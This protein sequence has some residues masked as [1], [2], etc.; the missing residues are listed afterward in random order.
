MNRNWPADWQ[1]DHIQGGAG[2]FPLSWP[3]TNC[4]AL[5]ILDHT[6]IAG[7]QSFHNNGGMILRGP[8]AVTRQD[9]T[10]AADDRIA[11][12][13]G[14]VGARMIPFYR[15]MVIYRDLYTVHGGFVNW[16]YEHLGIFSFTNELWNTDQMLGTPA[17]GGEAPANAVGA[18]RQ[19]GQLFA[20]DKLLF[21]A[22]FREWKP[23]KHPVYGE[24]EI[25]GFVKE[26]Q[27]VP[28]TFLIEELC[29]RNAAF[30]GY[31][32]DQMPKL[33]FGDVEVKPLNA[34]VF[35]VTATVKNTRAIPSVAAQAAAHRIGLPDILSLEG[36]GLSVLAGGRLVDTYTGEIDPVDRDPAH[37]KLI[38]GVPGLGTV[39]IRWLVK[40]TGEGTLK[41]VSQKGGTIAR[42]VTVK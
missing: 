9:A 42:G 40:G 18:T 5:F 30:V 35:A 2:D 36:P 10:P 24:I 37:Q 19:D 33:E 29:H 6:N 32:A 3:E 20:N 39:R 4:V 12:E 17:G 23:A 7:V 22:T 1:P 34:E 41:H 13:I 27:R 26:S 21:G 16:T 25:G 14:A 38:G 11:D 28:P 15:N 8:G 31:H